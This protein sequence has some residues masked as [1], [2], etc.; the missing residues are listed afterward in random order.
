MP[1]RLPGPARIDEVLR[2]LR[3]LADPARLAGM[4]R[5]GIG[6]D[7]ALGVTVTELRALARRIGRDHELAL[8]LWDTG[9]HEARMLATIV[10]EPSRVTEAQLEAWVLDLASWDLCDGLCGNLV[11]RTPFAFDKAAE[12]STRDEEFVKRA[13]FALIAWTAVHR[14][15]VED[16]AFEALLP[17]IREGATDDRNYVR[18]AVSWALRQVGKRSARLHVRAIETA[19]EIRGIDARSARWIASDVLRELTSDAVRERL[20]AGAKGAGP[21][22]RRGAG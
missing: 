14:K 2:E 21:R 18:K 12:W 3:R 6:T 11:D 17:L 1:E 7:A 13:G 19:E 20:A 22:R 9:I 15:D 16:A 4:A 8:G 10:D 5:F